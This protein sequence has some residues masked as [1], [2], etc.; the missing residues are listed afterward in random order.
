MVYDLPEWDEQLNLTASRQR[1]WLAN[2]VSLELIS[3]LSQAGQGMCLYGE[4]SRSVLVKG[5]QGWE[6]QNKRKEKGRKRDDAIM[7]FL[8]Q[9][10]QCDYGISL[11]MQIT[12]WETLSI[13]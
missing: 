3:L 5:K 12:S 7:Q 4:R 11:L 2:W 13:D 10:M 6:K 9:V 1:T 8:T